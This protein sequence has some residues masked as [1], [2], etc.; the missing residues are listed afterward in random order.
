M[1][2][3]Q[4]CKVFELANCIVWGFCCLLAFKSTDSNTKMRG[5]DHIDIISAISNGKRGFLWMS[6]FDHVN[7]FSFL[8][9]AY[10]TGKNDI[11]TFTKVDKTFLHLRVLLNDR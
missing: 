2:K 10:T 7:H 3:E 6:I 11:C 5:S 9:R 1:H 4:V 8:F